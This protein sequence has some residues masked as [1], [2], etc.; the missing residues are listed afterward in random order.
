MKRILIMLAA[1]LITV[2]VAD[3]R[4]KK[5]VS[6]TITDGVY[7][8]NRF[9]F[10]L[11]VHSNWQARMKKDEDNFRLVLTQKNYGIP[12]DYRSAQDYT[13]IPRLVIYADTSSMSP[14]DMLDSL[15]SSTFKSKQ[16]KEI[17]SEFEFLNQPDIIPKDKKMP[18]IG[19]KSGLVWKGESKYVKEI[20]ESQA[21]NAGMRVYGAYSGNVI[22]VKSDAG[23]MLVM[24][25]MC[26]HNFHDDVYAEVATMLNSLAFTPISK[27]DSE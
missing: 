17:L 8:D 5:E 7:Q 21:S 9:G 3:A 4:R 12:P 23:I 20:Q 11:T 13:Y 16:K 25:L 19:G 14:N 15:R 6:G 24:H 10:K 1:I 2:G 26:E 22:I 18:Q 27:D